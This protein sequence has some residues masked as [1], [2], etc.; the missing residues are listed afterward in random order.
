M[1][2]ALNKTQFDVPQLTKKVHLA[3]FYPLIQDVLD[4][5]STFTLTITGSSMWPTILGNRDRVTLVKPPER[6]KKYDLPLYR[7]ANGQ[8]VL[9][10][11][12]SVNE[13]GTYNC[14]G[15][16]QWQIERNLAHEQMVGLVVELERKGKAFSADKRSY[17][18]WV[19]FWC[20]LLRVRPFLFWVNSIWNRLKGKVWRLLHP[21]EAQSRAKKRN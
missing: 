16:H 10:R 15:D 21:R 1:R 13:D 14:C 5:G 4:S 7:R 20:F 12:V 17:R 11:I 6:L 8:F 3:E 9:H 19:R 18:C 2:A